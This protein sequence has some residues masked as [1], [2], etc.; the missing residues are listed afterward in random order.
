MFYKLSNQTKKNHLVKCILI[1]GLF[2]GYVGQITAEFGSLGIVEK[3]MDAGCTGAIKIIPTNPTSCSGTGNINTTMSTQ[4]QVKLTALATGIEDGWYTGNHNFTNR[5]AGQYRVE[6]RD[7]GSSTVCRDFIVTLFYR[8]PSIFNGRVINNAPN[9]N[10][11][12]SITFNNVQA[13]VEISHL[14]FLSRAYTTAVTGTNTINNLSPGTYGIR[15]RRISSPFCYIDTLITVGPIDCESTGLCG[16]SLGSNRFPGGDFGFGTPTQGPTLLSSETNYMYTPMTCD[17]PDDGAYSIV[18]NTDCN[19]SSSGG[20][21]FNGAFNILTE[22]HTTGDV[23]GYMMLVNAAYAPDIAFQKQITGLC[24]NTEYQF[25]AWIYNIQPAAGIKPNLT[26]V[27]DGVGR[28]TSGDITATVWQNVGFR[29]K[30]GAGT[31]STFSIRNNNPGGQGNDWVIDDIFVGICEPLVA[32]SPTTACIA[33][34][35]IIASATI[36]DAQTQFSWYKWQY[37]DNGTTWLDATSAAQATFTG[38]S[39]TVTYALPSPITLSIA[40]RQYRINV[41][42]SSSNLGSEL[43]SAISSGVLQVSNLNPGTVGSDQTVCSP[44][45]PALFTNVTSASGSGTI[46]YKWQIS[47]TSTSAGFNDITPAVTSATYNA[48]AGL[49]TTSYYRRLATSSLGSCSAISNVI[50]VEV[51]TITG[52]TISAAQTICVGGDPQTINGT[53]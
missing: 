13:G 51:N 27:I 44:G 31:T 45:D 14:T 22:D 47:T 52:G 43:C 50:T 5:P 24:P 16:S 33:D 48:P 28:Y 39:Y 10:G 41:A 3:I 36:T 12:G 35:N 9:C 40:G 8:D 2:F 17:A 15:L 20:G 23:G 19:G 34:V 38:T 32:V 53:N 46:T 11:T 21:I 7:I 37:S 26:F 4:Y 1:I 42:T 29:F 18:N 6:V 30:T 49:I 25:S